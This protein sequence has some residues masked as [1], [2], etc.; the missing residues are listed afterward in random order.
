MPN[1]FECKKRRHCPSPDPHFPADVEEKELVNHIKEFHPECLRSVKFT[2][3]VNNENSKKYLM[4]SHVKVKSDKKQVIKKIP[5]SRRSP[6]VQDDVKNCNTDDYNSMH[7]TINQ[8]T[9]TTL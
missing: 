2:M 5:L 7:A 1:S 9:K 8:H 4:L 6:V 3:Q